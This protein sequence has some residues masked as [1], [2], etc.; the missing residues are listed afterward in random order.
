[1]GSLKIKRDKTNLHTKGG[2]LSLLLSLSPPITDGGSPNNSGKNP[3]V[4][5]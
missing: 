4:W 3:L 1:M 5:E 2:I